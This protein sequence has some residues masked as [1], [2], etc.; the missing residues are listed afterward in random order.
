MQKIVSVVGGKHSGKT[1]VIE[2]LIA[3]LKSRQRRGSESKKKA[4]TAKPGPGK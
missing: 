2:Y 4:S 3:E 1:S